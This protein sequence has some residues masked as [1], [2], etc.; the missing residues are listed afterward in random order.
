MFLHV[1]TAAAGAWGALSTA[2]MASH[3]VL[4]AV[5][6]YCLQRLLS[7]HRQT[8]AW[9]LDCTPMSSDACVS[10]LLCC[11]TNALLCCD[12]CICRVLLSICCCQAS[13]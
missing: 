11:C 10:W 4:C 12:M 1:F 6:H 13:L 5:L 2:T 3:T 7:N 9:L 8:T